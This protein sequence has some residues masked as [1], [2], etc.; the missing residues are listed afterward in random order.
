MKQTTKQGIAAGCIVGAAIL[1]IIATEGR[2]PIV[3]LLAIL[4]IL[5]GMNASFRQPRNRHS[6]A[7]WVLTILLGWTGLGWV[8][9]LIWS[10]MDQPPLQAAALPALIP[11][12]VP[13]PLPRHFSKP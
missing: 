4:Y 3:T 10:Y 7:I 1:E 8:I 2:L 13:A 6:A 9:A 5:P 12:N 11:N